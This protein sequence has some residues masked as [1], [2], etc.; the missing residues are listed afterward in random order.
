M[1]DIIQFLFDV[2]VSQIVVGEVIQW[3][4]LVVKEFMEN[5]IDV[6]VDCIQLIIKESGKNLIQIIDNGCG[7][8]EFD[9]WMCF[10]CYVISKFCVV[11]DLIYICIMGFWGEVMVIVVVIVQVELKICCYVDELGMCVLMEGFVF[12]LQ[13]F[14]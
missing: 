9:V 5:V 2:I 13:E 10:E 4:V 6:G 12:K 11:D 8:L 1:L 14:C 3:F 7:M